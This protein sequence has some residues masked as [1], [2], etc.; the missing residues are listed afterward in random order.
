MR[1]LRLE[2]FLPVTRPEKRP[3]KFFVIIPKLV[4]M[5]MGIVASELLDVVKSEAKVDRDK[6]KGT[7]IFGTGVIG[8]RLVVFMDIYSLY[9]AAE[10]EVY[11][12]LS[13]HGKMDGKKALLAEDTAFFR[14]VTTKYLEEQGCVVRAVTDGQYAWEALCGA[15][16]FDI[17]ITD[18]NM[19]RMNGLELTKKVRGSGKFPGLPIVALTSMGLDR[20]RKTGIEAG[21]TRYELKLDKER[22]LET[23]RHVFGVEQ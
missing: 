7:G 11:K 17:L 9:E 8:E 15:E 14:M 10:P 20:D 4:R 5:P 23:L 2:N 3:D 18:V 16:R 12:N 22:L 19:P 1:L 6:V 21:V 13:S